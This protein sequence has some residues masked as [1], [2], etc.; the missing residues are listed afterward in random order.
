MKTR[1]TI[2]QPDGKSSR[3]KFKHNELFE[4]PSEVPRHPKATPFF[5]KM[6]KADRGKTEVITPKNEVPDFILQRC[7]NVGLDAS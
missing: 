4:P 2:R 6:V 7:N 3:P 1:G 5:K